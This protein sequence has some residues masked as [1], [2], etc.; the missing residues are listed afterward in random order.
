[1]FSA[2]LIH[3]R[4]NRIEINIFRCQGR[5]QSP[6]WL[7]KI[8]V[9]NI[10]FHGSSAILP[11]TYSRWHFVIVI[12]LSTGSFRRCSLDDCSCKQVTILILFSVEMINSRLSLAISHHQTRTFI[13]KR[14]KNVINKITT[15][16]RVI[17]EYNCNG[18]SMPW[19]ITKNVLQ[20]N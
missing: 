16:R 5:P 19:K 8:E 2:S 7:S 20:L 13:D 14:N 1:M 9:Y 6:I 11:I 15:P 3:L 4:F 12:I 18:P 10:E 17:V